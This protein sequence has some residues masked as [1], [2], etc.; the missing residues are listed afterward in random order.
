MNEAFDLEVAASRHMP[1]A[2]GAERT[3][4][5]SARSAS[6]LRCQILSV[7]VTAH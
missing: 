3:K 6:K 4:S 7:R 2:T 1:T 5:F